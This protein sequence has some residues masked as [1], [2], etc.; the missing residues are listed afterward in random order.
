[1]SRNG[2][3]VYSKATGTT[4][5][6]GS[7]ITSAQ[8]NSSIDD[9]VDDLNAARPVTAGGT[10]ATSASAARTALGVAYTTGGN[11]TNGYY[12]R[13]PSGWQTCVSGPLT[14]TRTSNAIAEATWTLP[15]AF[16]GSLPVW[17]SLCALSNTSADYTGIDPGSIATLQW[18]AISTPTTSITLRL[19]RTEGGADWTAA[20]AVANVRV[21][22]EGFWS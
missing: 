6:P 10:G 22:A 11:A 19:R 20:Q 13:D 15:A 9:I 4:A 8:F 17:V 7:T 2:S 12:L 5:T 16:A 3:G 14:F 18:T 1:M 21:R